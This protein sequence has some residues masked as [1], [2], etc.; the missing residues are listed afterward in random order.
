MSDPCP[1]P[2]EAV[3][4][5]PPSGASAG[6]V[7]TNRTVSVS[8]MNNIETAPGQDP[9]SGVTP[10]NLTLLMSNLPANIQ[11][12]SAGRVGKSEVPSD[13]STKPQWTIFI[14]GVALY[15]IR[16]RDII[17]DDETYQY[18]VAA[19]EWT[20]FGYTLFCVRLEV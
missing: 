10:A 9:Y 3:A 7:V 1:L 19:A 17:Q 14:P 12:K 8:R 2:W 18:G 16:D 4:I 6:P 20:T 15:A 13:I 11:V 5:S